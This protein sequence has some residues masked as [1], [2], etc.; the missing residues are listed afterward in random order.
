MLNIVRFRISDQDQNHFLPVRT[1]FIVALP[2][3]FCISN[4][5]AGFLIR[6]D[7]LRRI[8][9]GLDSESELLPDSSDS[10]VSC[11]LSGSSGAGSGVGTDSSSVKGP[12][13]SLPLSPQTNKPPVHQKQ[14]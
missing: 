14:D 3:S 8:C 5:V 10:A 4:T 12:I 9:S 11:S 6:V 7:G 2:P 13:S 1:G